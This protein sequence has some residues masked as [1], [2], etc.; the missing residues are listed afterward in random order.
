MN[1]ARHEVITA[2]AH[3]WLPSL[4]WGSPFYAHLSDEIF[5]RPHVIRD[6]ICRR[7]RDPQ[8]TVD[9]AKVVM[10]QEQSQRCFKIVP[11]FRECEV[12]RVS[13]LHHWRSVPR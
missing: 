3:F 5:N 12:S 10:R 4:Q 1:H 8:R 6:T 11:L 13:P 2:V 7:W 9:P